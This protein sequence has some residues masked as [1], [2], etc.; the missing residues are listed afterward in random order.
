MANAH[1]AI[2][3]ARTTIAIPSGNLSGGADTKLSAVVDA[4]DALAAEFADFRT[5]AT[6]EIDELRDQ[7]ADARSVD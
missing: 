5:K 1:K 3:D 4:L 6:A 7:L 2:E